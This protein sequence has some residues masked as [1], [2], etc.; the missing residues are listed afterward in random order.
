MA[1]N[2]VHLGLDLYASP[3][4]ANSADGKLENRRVADF[5]ISAELSRD[6]TDWASRWDLLME[7]REGSLTPDAPEM[8]QF[9]REG[10]ELFRRLVAELGAQRDVHYDSPIYG[11]S[12]C[13]HRAGNS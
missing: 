10:G 13:I 11:E 4:W 3:L 1:P 8:R 6:L 5:P 7:A 9:D 2:A 12:Y